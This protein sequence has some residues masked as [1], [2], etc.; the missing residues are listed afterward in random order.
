[1]LR[2]KTSSYGKLWSPFFISY[3]ISAFL[4]SFL[5]YF[6]HETMNLVTEFILLNLFFTVTTLS[7]YLLIKNHPTIREQ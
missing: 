6:I 1:M 5:F 7:I 4:S 2:K 3:I